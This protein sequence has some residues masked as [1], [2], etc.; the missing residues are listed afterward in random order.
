[1]TGHRE[2]GFGPVARL[3]VPLLAVGLLGGHIVEGQV[4]KYA[5]TDPL[6][7]TPSKEA[8]VL[9]GGCFWGVDAVFK[10]VQGVK[11]VLSGYSGGKPQTAEYELV[12][13]GRTGHAESVKVIAHHVRRRPVDGCSSASLGS[14]DVPSD[15]AAIVT[16]VIYTYMD[17][18]Q[19][20]AGRGRRTRPVL[21]AVEEPLA[22]AAK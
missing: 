22:Q 3:R 4:P 20:W 19:Q 5:G 2:R 13:T 18:F 14:E 8:A 15:A 9:A 11:Q 21:A 10:H 12:S 17:S 16:P 1:M 6:A 7:S